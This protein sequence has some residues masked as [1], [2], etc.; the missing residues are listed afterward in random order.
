MFPLFH[1]KMVLFQ[2]GTELI[3]RSFR[4]HI[5]DV[6]NIIKTSCKKWPRNIT[7]KKSVAGGK[8]TLCLASPLCTQEYDQIPWS[9]GVIERH[10][11]QLEG[12]RRHHGLIGRG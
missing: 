12:S 3:I 8:G 11:S 9:K 6:A 5:S 4:I 1:I 2:I 10:I 7:R